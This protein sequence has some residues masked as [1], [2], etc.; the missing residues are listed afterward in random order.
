MDDQYISVK[1]F[2]SRAGVSP[3]AIYQ[4]LDKDLK[5]FFKVVE[6]QK[7]LD[8]KALDVFVLKQVEQ[9]GDKQV[10]NILKCFKE[11][12]KTL[13]EQLSVKDKQIESNYKQ[14]E[15]KDNQIADL[16][17]RLR[18]A[19]ELNR[20]NQILLGSEQNRINIALEAT[21]DGGR[22]RQ[23]KRSGFFRKIFKGD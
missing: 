5:P 11:T 16:N 12:L 4:R 14:L 10:E 19:Q 9:E 1:D 23:A 13:E 17:E 20:N 2:A 21:E 18:E 3:Q 6:R 22:D 7:R 15:V 8:I